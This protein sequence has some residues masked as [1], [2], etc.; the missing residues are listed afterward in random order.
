MSVEIHAAVVEGIVGAC[1]VVF[2]VFVAESLRRAGER[3]DRVSAVVMEL[4]M[5][6]PV[7]GNMFRNAELHGDLRYGNDGWHLHQR[8]TEL[9][10]T[11][12]SLIRPRLWNRF[13]RRAAASR[14]VSR[15]SA[16]LHGY[17]LRVTVDGESISILEFT[18]MCGDDLAVIHRFALESRKTE[19]QLV[20]H[21]R[22]SGG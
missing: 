7:L 18:E 3:K 20:D 5:K 19:D 15:L 21:Y 12:H 9:V 6:V 2:G 13:G 11:A 14:A 17:F 1:A 4:T 22:A 8:V 10:A 16:R